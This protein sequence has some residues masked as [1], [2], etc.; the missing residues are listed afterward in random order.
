MTEIIKHPTKAIAAKVSDWTSLATFDDYNEGLMSRMRKV[1]ERLLPEN[2]GIEVI[3]IDHDPEAVFETFFMG[4]EAVTGKHYTY[5]YADGIFAVWGDNQLVH[6][7]TYGDFNPEQ[8]ATLGAGPMSKGKQKLLIATH[9][10]GKAKEFAAMLAPLGYEV[11][12]LSAYPELPEVA[13]TGMTFEENAR[14]KAETISEITGQMVLADDSG[15][16]VDVLGGLPG[17][18]S[19]RFAGDHATDEDN[20]N[21]LM[22]E[23]ASTALTPE[24]R[25]AQFH[26]TL[27]VASPDK[28]S[29]V[30]EA[31]W[32]GSILITPR[33]DNGF[34]YDPY[35]QPDD[36]GKSAAEMSMEEKNEKSHRAQALRLLVDALPDWLNQ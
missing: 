5:Q 26:A 16:C 24:R 35:F 8:F 22:H 2:V 1:G 14:L 7:E 31:D 18:W 6:V 15:L 12:D 33:G 4:V 30:V 17:V 13:E 21:K 34:G 10:A 28:E 29:L 20:N 25:T 9:N 23:L 11:E 27:V 3:A 32:P 19:A 36:S